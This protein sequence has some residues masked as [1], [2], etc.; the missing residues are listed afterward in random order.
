[1]V[2]YQLFKVLFQ[3]QFHITCCLFASTITGKHTEIATK[4]SK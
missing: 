3:A 4:I 1:M 2:N